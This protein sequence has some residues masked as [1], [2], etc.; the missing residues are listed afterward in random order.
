MPIS[1]VNMHGQITLPVEM[2]KKLG[3]TPGSVVEISEK[4]NCLEVKKATVVESESLKRL[5]ELARRKGI[6]KKEIIKACREAGEQVYAE[7][8]PE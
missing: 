6:T 5:A 4:S 3:M 8:Y 2:R 7:E 1:Q